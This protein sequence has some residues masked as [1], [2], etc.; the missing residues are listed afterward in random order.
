[1]RTSD[2][3]SP[4]AAGILVNRRMKA[5]NQDRGPTANSFSGVTENSRSHGDL[6]AKRFFDRWRFQ[7]K[8]LA[9]RV[10]D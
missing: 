7:V 10:K 6:I 5:K 2:A 1:M 9:T 8:A 4:R 3:S